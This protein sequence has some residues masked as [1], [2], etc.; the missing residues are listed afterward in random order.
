M[1][2]RLIEWCVAELPDDDVP[3]SSKLY[4]VKRLNFTPRCY[5]QNLT[6]IDVSIGILL[7]FVQVFFHLLLFKIPDRCTAI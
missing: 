1:T 7:Y 2:Q 5:I 3:D 6:N 4:F